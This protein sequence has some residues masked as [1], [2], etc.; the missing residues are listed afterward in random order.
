[1]NKLSV[2][3]IIFIMFI[4]IVSAKT[5]DSSKQFNTNATLGV[6]QFDE[7][8]TFSS[9]T[10]SDTTNTVRFEDLKMSDAYIWADIGFRNDDLSN[11]M[12]ITDIDE[13]HVYYDLTTNV[14][15]QAVWF[16]VHGNPTSVTGGTY[17]IDG[18]NKII[19]VS[20]NAVS[21]IIT[22]GGIVTHA[23]LALPILLFTLIAL[24]T[25]SL[26]MAIHGKR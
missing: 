16:D 26:Y 17:V 24:L 1:M 7:T 3:V 23:P 11:I 6:I 2:F 13:F 5:I 21:V 8:T 22:W 10:M 18:V 12:L 14:G 15:N 20:A 4:P 25:V 19:E 9:M